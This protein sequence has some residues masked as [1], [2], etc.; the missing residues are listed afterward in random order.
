MIPTWQEY[1]FDMAKTATSRS[2][3]KKAS[4][5]AVIVDPQTK[6]IIATGYNGTPSGIESCKER[7]NCYRIDNNIE[8]GTRYETCRSIH[9]EQN[10]IIQ[11]GQERCRWKHMYLYGHEMVCIL[12]KRFI[13][14]SGI[15]KVFLRKGEGYEI[16]IINVREDWRDL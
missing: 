4:V 13:I 8:S 11:A 12:C 7:G 2:N 1:F 6:F 16:K 5:G 9:A 10:A 15:T 14:Q 3:C